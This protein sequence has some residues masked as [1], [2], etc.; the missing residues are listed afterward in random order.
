M[1]F[2]P[3]TSKV[4]DVKKSTM[5]LWR[6]NMYLFCLVLQYIEPSEGLV[7]CQNSFFISYQNSFCQE[8]RFNV[9]QSWLKRDLKKN[10]EILIRSRFW[11]F[12]IMVIFHHKQCLEW[13]NFKIWLAWLWNFC[14]VFDLKTVYNVRILKLWLF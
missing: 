4:N 1:E 7:F 6:G 10:S 9:K 12:E 3:S 14:S 2:L 11:L 8:T 5:M 13:K